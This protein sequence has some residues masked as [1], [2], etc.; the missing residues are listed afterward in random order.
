[1]WRALAL[2]LKLISSSGSARDDHA[3]WAG[4]TQS[5][6]TRTGRPMSGDTYRISQAD[7]RMLVRFKRQWWAVLEGEFTP[8]GRYLR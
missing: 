8:E 6:I 1:M 2:N 3:P 5:P 4:K 7:G